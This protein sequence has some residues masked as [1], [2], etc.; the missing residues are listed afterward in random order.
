MSEI[1][2]AT[3]NPIDLVKIGTVGRPLPGI[4]L[5]LADDGEV[6]MRGATR[7]LGY[8]NLPD[9]TAETI[10]AQGWLHSGDIGE[11]D[12]D[13]YLRIIDRKKEMIIM[14]PGATCLRLTSKPA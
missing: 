7:M 8:R 1:C 5:C 12:E 3:I 11:F 4:E 6:L 10:D 9:K 14:S 13:G 2:L